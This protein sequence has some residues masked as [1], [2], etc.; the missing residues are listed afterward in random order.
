[1]LMVLNS[2]LT[3]LAR[4]ILIL[5]LFSGSALCYEN[6]A[7]DYGRGAASFSRGDYITALNIWLPLAQKGDPAAQYSIGLLYD[8]GSGVEKDTPLALDYLQ[9]AAD[10]GLPAAQYYLAIKYYNAFDVKKDAYKARQLLLKA[11]RQEHLK[12]QFQLANLYARG[13]GGPEDQKQ[14]TYWFITASENGFGSAQ[15]SLAARFLTGKGTDV[16]IGRGIFWLTKAA[17]QQNTDALRDLGFMY[18]K[19]V[20]VKKNYQQASD[21]LQLPAEEK[22]ALALFLLGKIYAQ[23]GYG[24]NRDINQAKKWYQKAQTLGYKEADIEL[25]KLSEK[26][27]PSKTIKL[28][29]SSITTVTEKTVV[30]EAEP[31]TTSY[32]ARESL[33]MVDNARHFKKLNGNYYTIQLLSTLEFGSITVLTN[34]FFDQHTYVLKTPKGKTA[35][36]LSYGAYKN[37][38]DALSAALTL[39]KEFQ[40]SSKPWIRTVK[41]LQQLML[42]KQ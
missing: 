27:A 13:E 35:Y 12:A 2:C 14:A 19:G 34:Q 41:D 17:N 3:S 20:G 23:G 6:N 37:R 25:Q 39:P 26:I 28:K 15:H 42:D 4:S 11:A 29:S 1:M 33:T 36:V 5:L 22:S 18:Y 31:E 24:V 38:H 10:Q 30:P 7:A 21:L 9:S 8:Q 16:N 32:S 40:L